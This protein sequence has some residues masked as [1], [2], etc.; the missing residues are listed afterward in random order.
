MKLSRTTLSIILAA[1]VLVS[2][3]IVGLVIRQAR[4]GSVTQNQL[5]REPLPKRTT[6]PTLEERERIKAARAQKL[7]ENRNLTP[8]QKEQRLKD[9]ARRVSPDQPNNANVTG[10]RAPVRMQGRPVPTADANSR[11][12]ARGQTPPSPS[13]QNANSGA[14]TQD[15]NRPK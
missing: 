12:S 15:A 8:E 10:R 5:P 6:Q 3:Y 9:L 11:G 2:A 14:S 4:V 7:E 13:P 1:V